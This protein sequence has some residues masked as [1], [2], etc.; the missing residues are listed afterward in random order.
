MSRRSLLLCLAIGMA[1]ADSSVVTL[2][3][4]EVLREF[5]VG[6]TTVAWVLT[7][8]NL[9]L[10]VLAV[11]AALVAR[12]RPVPAFVVGSVVFAAASLACGVAPSFE[13]LVG[14]RCV[15][16]AGGALVV[17]A[18][19]DLLSETEGS[20]SGA[21]R[22]WVTAGVAGA[23]IGPAIGGV[24]T[25][26]IGWEWIFLLQAPLALLPLVAVRGLPARPLPEPPGRPSITANLALLFL[27]GGLVAA[28]F[29]LVLLL[30]DGWGMSPALAG[31]VVTVVPAA[32]I[33]SA[34][35]APRVG[36]VAMRT[37][38]G[39]VLVTGGL[40]AL[41]LL[42]GAAWWWTVAPQLLVG[43]GL[44][45]SVAALTEWAVADG[46]EQVV[47]GGWTIA[48]R[49]AGVVVGL[50]LLAPVLTSALDTNKREAL[51]AGAAVVLDSDIPPLDK[52]RVAQDVLVQV[53]AA[54]NELPDVAA[55]FEDR[56]DTDEYRGLL[57]ALEDQLDRAVTDAFSGPFALAAGLTLLSLAVVGIGAWRRT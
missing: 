35:Q 8:Y 33:V 39:V 43:A 7:S 11:P 21:L 56:P 41:A 22:A 48:A 25:Q 38:T 42:P 40:V 2:A 55:A 30:V 3:L 1:L 15:Q 52:L 10:A 16:A 18:A 19:L 27:S 46:S 50:L 23:A 36:G 51:Y 28:L 57:A 45:L 49:H 13:V 14:A 9:V 24:L 6:I 31:A 53:D 5:D 54:E 12:R 26:T 44:G 17:G 32:A 29:L 4:P 47:Q 20:A 37:A 34:R